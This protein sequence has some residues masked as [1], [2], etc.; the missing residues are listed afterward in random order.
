MNHRNINS[1]S[2][3]LSTCQGALSSSTRQSRNRAEM[4]THTHTHAQGCLEQSAWHS[5]LASLRILQCSQVQ[6]RLFNDSFAWC[7]QYCTE[8]SQLV[9][10]INSACIF[11][12]GNWSNKPDNECWNICC[13]RAWNCLDK[14]LTLG[15]KKKI[16][17]CFLLPKLDMHAY[18]YVSIILHY[19]NM[20]LLSYYY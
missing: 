11:L 1:P 12:A 5:R 18:I 20:I 10:L 4:S 6:G 16:S 2:H 3:E 14:L 15:K 8:L 17:S 13:L 9:F 7:F 19:Y